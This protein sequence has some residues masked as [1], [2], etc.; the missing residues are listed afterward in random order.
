VGGCPATV[1]GNL[2]V[3]E[4]AAS[5]EIVLPRDM[6]NGRYTLAW[7]WFNRRGEREMYM[8]CAPVMVSGGTN[9]NN[10][11]FFD[12]LPDMFVANLPRAACATV[13]EHDVSF[14]QPGDAVQTGEQAKVA[15]S[16]VGT[17]CESV[18]RRGA[19]AGTMRPPVDAP[20]WRT[21]AV[22]QTPPATKTPPVLQ[23]NQMSSIPA[24]SFTAS[25]LEPGGPPCVPCDDDGA[26]V[27][28]G[29]L[30]FGICDRRCAYVQALAEGMSCL[31][32]VIVKHSR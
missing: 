31:A 18:T 9:V 3:G 15:T 20:G 7:T 4:T 22:S 21:I 23:F 32:G 16:L 5:F 10:A 11:A 8:N 6:P 19:G 12:R 30:H 27:C 14:P 1:V 26:V 29:E 25:S 24:A 13:D 17:G 28:I 2:A